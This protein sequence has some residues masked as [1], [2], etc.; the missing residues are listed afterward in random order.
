MMMKRGSKF[1]I[2]TLSTL[3]MAGTA[4]AQA[5]GEEGATT[6]DATAT[7]GTTDGTATDGTTDGTATDGTATDGTTDGTTDGGDMGGDMAAEGA[8]SMILAKGKFA[9]VLPIDVNLSK[10]FAGKPISITPDIWYGVMPKLQVGLAHSGMALTGFWAGGLGG[11]LCV[12]GEDNGCAKVYNG[13]VGLAAN[14]GLLDDGKLAL[15]ADVAVIARALDPDFLLGAKVGVKGR[16]MAGKIGIGFN[17]NVYI[18]FTERDAGNKEVLNVP[19]DLGFMVN[20]K[21]MVGLQT[22]ITGPLDGFGDA[23]SLPV[24]VGGVFTATPNINVGA[25][26]NLLR[27]ASGVDGNEAFD[28]RSLTV[29]AEYHN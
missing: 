13:P 27:V 20:P 22:G 14:Y 5:E 23:W 18:G 25:S 1:L 12:T 7:D 11:G 15:A 24:S 19:V 6:D 8:P 26:F 4:A 17:P 3:A 21:I 2:V 10:D 9:I 28:N 29:F 16:Y